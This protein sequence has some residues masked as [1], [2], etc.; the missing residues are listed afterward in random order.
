MYLMNVHCLSLYSK[1]LCSVVQLLLISI[2][3]NP[4]LVV[5]IHNVARSTVKLFVLVFLDTLEHL[6]LVDQ[7]VLQVL[8]VPRMKLVTIRNVSTLA[9]ELVESMQ[10]VKSETTIQS[11]LACKDILEIHSS[12]VRWKS[13]NNLLHQIL[14]NHLLVVRIL[15]VELSESKHLVHVFHQ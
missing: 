13:S 2:L 1:S 6:Q 8:N 14:V 11:V 3:V 4:H 5:Q 7:S 12:D 9:L 10:T 15:N